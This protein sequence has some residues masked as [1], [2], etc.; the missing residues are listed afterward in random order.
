MNCKTAAILEL[1]HIAADKS[2]VPFKPKGFR[3]LSER[4]NEIAEKG[5][6][7]ITPRY[8]NENIKRQGERALDSGQTTI[9]LRLD[10]VNLIARYCGYD[11]YLAWQKEWEKRHREVASINESVLDQCLLGCQGF[12]V[13]YAWSNKNNGDILCAPVEVFK[14]KGKVLCRLEGNNH[15]FEGALTLEKANLFVT[16]KSKKVKQ[17]HIVFWIG[18]HFRPSVLIGVFSGVASGGNPICGREV[19]VRVEEKM[20]KQRV[21]NLSECVDKRDLLPEQIVKFFRTHNENTIKI[22]PLPT[23]CDWDD[24]A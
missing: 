2:N 18:Y 14:D 1:L 12:W 9:S 21:I 7:Y 10:Y 15:V 11:T 4:I 19:W 17:M 13:S 24:F 5:S 23:N 22:T 3:I 16:L 20:D 8:L 6:V